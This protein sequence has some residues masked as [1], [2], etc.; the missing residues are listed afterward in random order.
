MNAIRFSCLFPVYTIT[1]LPTFNLSAMWQPGDLVQNT[2]CSDISSRIIYIFPP[3]SV[4]HI[5]D[6]LMSLF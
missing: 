4:I 3:I 5:D 1:P 6:T 2:H